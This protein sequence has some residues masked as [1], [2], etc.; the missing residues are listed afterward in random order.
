MDNIICSIAFLDVFSTKNAY[1]K[2]TKKLGL[3]NPPPTYFG[4]SP[5]FLHFLSA[6]LTTNTPVGPAVPEQ[7][8]VVEEQR[9]H[10]QD[11]GVVNRDDQ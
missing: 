10:R 7:A 6:S 8:A 2:N 9:R 3:P 4:P 1:Q 11:D 5:K